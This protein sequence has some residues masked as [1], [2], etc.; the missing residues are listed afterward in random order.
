MAEHL[1]TPPLPEYL[2]LK[3]SIFVFRNFLIHSIQVRH[4][5]IEE[6]L[7]PEFI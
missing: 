6:F 1:P 2:I 4:G 5:K 3:I 7:N